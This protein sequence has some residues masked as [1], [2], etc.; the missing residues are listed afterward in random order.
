MRLAGV[1][2]LGETAD[3][4]ILGETEVL[5]E[6]DDAV[7][8]A[9]RL[10]RRRGY[11]AR[12]G[13]AGDGG[14]PLDARVAQRRIGGEFREHGAGF[15]G[16]ELILVAQQD[17]VR[18]GRH[19]LDQLGGERQV[20]HRRLVDDEEVDRQRIAR[21]VAE[22]VG[23]GQHAQQAVNGERLRG[24]ALAQVGGQV[25]GGVADRFQHPRGGLAGRGRQ[26]DPAVRI[27][28]EYAGEHVDDG[29]RLAGAGAAADDRQGPFERQCRRDLLPVGAIAQSLRVGG[30]Q[31]VE[32]RL[33][34]VSDGA[35][36]GGHG[37][38]QPLREPALVVEVAVQVEA[39][40]GVEDQRVRSRHLRRADHP[41]VE[42][43]AAQRRLIEVSAAATMSASQAHT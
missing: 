41:R 2:V 3:A 40:V 37:L 29:G 34:V 14:Q 30:E 21:V 33:H 15:D 13:D 18:R 32:E 35:R 10:D 39:A 20:Q 27:A 6:P 38:H 1:D 28:G 9:R 5:G 42:Q 43:R 17:D 12:G 36:F 26:A 7:V 31:A 8:E 22:L 19:G 23:V 24:Q 4:G 25:S 11:D 16:G